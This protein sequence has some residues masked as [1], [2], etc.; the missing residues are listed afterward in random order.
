[1]S[2][3]VRVGLNGFGR[4]GRN[5]MRASLDNDNV[6]IVG[7]NDVM[8]DDEIDYFAKYDTVMGELP[9]ASVDAGVLSVD[10]TDF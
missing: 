5:V 3:P 6:E 9:E 1:M 2:D 10:G 4:I 7:I 8:D